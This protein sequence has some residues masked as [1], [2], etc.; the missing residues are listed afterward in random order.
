MGLKIKDD[1]VAKAR[2]DRIR[3]YLLS[4]AL[5]KRDCTDVEIKKIYGLSDADFEAAANILVKDGI[6]E[7][8]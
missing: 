5:K 3:A 2:S 7:R 1:Y 8:E 4:K 6:A